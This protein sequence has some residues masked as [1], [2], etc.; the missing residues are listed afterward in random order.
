LRDLEMCV[1]AETELP[2]CYAK[3][4]GG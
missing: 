3:A 1:T 4:C 2:A